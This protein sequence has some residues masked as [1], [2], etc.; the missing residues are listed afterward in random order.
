MPCNLS[1]RAGALDECQN[2]EARYYKK[3][4]W[5][6]GEDS[7][8]LHPCGGRARE[9]HGDACP[10]S[11]DAKPQG[12]GWGVPFYSG[13]MLAAGEVCVVVTVVNQAGTNQLS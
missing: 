10:F 6:D 3:L 11:C 5:A 8:V 9:S 12:I 4:S 1:E 7:A 13:G 2:V